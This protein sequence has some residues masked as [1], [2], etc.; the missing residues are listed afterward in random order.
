[1][2]LLRS[3]ED[4]PIRLQPHL[5]AELFVPEIAP[6]PCVKTAMRFSGSEL[7]HFFRAIHQQRTSLLLVNRAGLCGIIGLILIHEFDS[8]VGDFSSPLCA[9][10]GT[11]AR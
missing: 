10:A 11:F 7:F 4:T 1:M 6:F 5:D 8:F 9:R 3:Q 2:L